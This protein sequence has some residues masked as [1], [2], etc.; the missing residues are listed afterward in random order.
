[1]ACNLKKRKG[2][3]MQKQGKKRIGGGMLAVMLLLTGCGEERPEPS[4][5]I[6]LPSPTV[7]DTLPEAGESQPAPEATEEMQM[8]GRL[9]VSLE[10]P[11]GFTQPKE[12]EMAFYAPTYPEDGSSIVLTVSEKDMKFSF[13]DE[14]SYGQMMKNS[15]AAM[16]EQFY[17]ETVNIEV[18]FFEKTQVDGYP[19][20]RAET[21]YDFLGEHY[22]QMQL[23][24]DTDALYSFVFTDISE[25][26]PQWMQAYEQSA[27]SIRFAERKQ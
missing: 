2:E 17:G 9:E 21:A 19:A 23:L 11:E 8:P 27:E 24:I 22:T 25:G 6:T 4:E 20:I 18:T 15:V 12:G 26:E 3:S 1:M 10:P 7:S 5:T 13:I 16:Y 14:A